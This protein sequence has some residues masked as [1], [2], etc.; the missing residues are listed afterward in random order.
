MIKHKYRLRFLVCLA[1]FQSGALPAFAGGGGDSYI[2]SSPDNTTPVTSS[3]PTNTN[4]GTTATQPTIN[5][6]N[7]NPSSYSPS[8]SYNSQTSGFQSFKNNNSFN[9]QQSSSYSGS[10]GGSN[11]RCGLTVYAE[12]DNANNLLK[13]TYQM[14]VSWS[15]QK[16]VDEEKLHNQEIE[17]DKIQIES[18]LQQTKIEAQT[19]VIN[20]CIAERS[21]ALA[22]N[23]N[24]D[25]VCLKPDI[26]KLD[27]LY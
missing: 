19:S 20:N 16:C 11:N 27:A 22:Q 4:S 21:R 3:I 17:V 12:R 7:G 25:D 18:Q 14:G 26:T 2:P 24:P 6:T 10:F 8:T 5:Y 1:C 13:D 23:L 15:Q 9:Y